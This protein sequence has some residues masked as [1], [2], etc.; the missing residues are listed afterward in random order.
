LHAG[1]R[2]SRASFERL[3]E[4]VRSNPKDAG[5][6]VALARLYSDREFGDY[7][8]QRARS[9][10]ADAAALGSTEAKMIQDFSTIQNAKSM[11]DARDSIKE[12]QSLAPGDPLASM[13]LGVLLGEGTAVVPKD[14]SR[15]IDLLK[16]AADNRMVQSWVGLGY[17]YAEQEGGTAHAIDCYSKAASQGSPA[18]CMQLVDRYLDGNGVG[19][20]PKMGFRLMQQASETSPDAV[21]YLGQMYF[22]GTGVLADP[23]QARELV[24]ESA[25]QGSAV[26][27]KMLSEIYLDGRFGGDYNP[28]LGLHWLAISGER[29]NAL[30]L[31]AYGLLKLTGLGV[32]RDVEQSRNLFEA[33]KESGIEGNDADMVDLMLA[34]AYDPVKSQTAFDA[35]LAKKGS[36]PGFAKTAAFLQLAGKVSD[37]RGLTA[38]VLLKGAADNG[39][40]LARLCYRLLQDRDSKY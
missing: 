29:G 5:A 35:M 28:Q 11:E 18:A 26:G 21:A 17:I 12:L 38:E 10:L 20:D 14:V 39:D 33:A 8:P 9:A 3:R 30:G 13:M 15:A 27:A 1:A 6:L 22:D 19:K 36:N 31:A 37:T 7:S 34:A 25:D 2:P 16:F 40:P 23:A 4:R 24:R 32:N